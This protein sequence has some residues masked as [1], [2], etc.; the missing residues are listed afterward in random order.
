MAHFS[1]HNLLM[2]YVQQQGLLAL[3]AS[4]LLLFTSLVYSEPLF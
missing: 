4:L 3:C 2:S 1:T